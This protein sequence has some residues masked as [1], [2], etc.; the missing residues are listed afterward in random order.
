MSMLN[1]VIISDISIIIFSIKHT[2]PSGR[3]VMLISVPDRID[4]EAR[5]SSI[6]TSDRHNVSYAYLSYVKPMEC[7]PSDP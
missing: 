7:Q 5:A 4:G 2:H 1:A 3:N 6:F